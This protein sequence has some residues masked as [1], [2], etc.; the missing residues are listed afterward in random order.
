MKIEKNVPL[1]TRPTTGDE[2]VREFVRLLK[3]MEVMDSVAFEKNG[4]TQQVATAAVSELCDYTFQGRRDGMQYR[5]W[6][7]R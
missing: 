4:M 1:P 5:L 6:R 7:I 2:P 3:S